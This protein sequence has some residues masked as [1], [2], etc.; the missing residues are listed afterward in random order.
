MTSQKGDTAVYLLYSYIRLCSILRKSGI[1]EEEIQKADFHFTDPAELS[2]ARHIVKFYE[3][4]EFAA[5]KMALNY[6]CFYLYSLSTKIS[7]AMN[8][9]YI[10][11]NE[12]T[13]ERVKLIFAT[14]LV[15]KKCFDLLGI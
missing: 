6:I 9:Y 8:K 4:I 1:S 13:K 11:N 12:N 3:T 5:D 2:I 15:M 14:K 10:N 7:S